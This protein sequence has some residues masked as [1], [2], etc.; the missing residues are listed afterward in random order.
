M[1]F[2]GEGQEYEFL[3]KLPDGWLPGFWGWMKGL[4][5]K[6]AVQGNFGGMVELFCVLAVMI[7]TAMYTF[8]HLI[9]H[10]YMYKLVELYT[11]SVHIYV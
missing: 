2:P 9:I 1:G 6:G 11:K 8:T 7:A 10:L 5:T 4:T 3:K